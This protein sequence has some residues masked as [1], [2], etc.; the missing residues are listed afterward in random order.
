MTSTGVRVQC[1]QCTFAV[2]MKSET[3][4]P[5]GISKVVEG[6][7][8]CPNCDMPMKPVASVDTST[9]HSNPGLGQGLSFA[10]RLEAIRSAEYEVEEAERVLK[11]RKAD[12]TE[13]RELYDAKVVSLRSIINRLTSVPKPGE[14]P[15]LDL[16]AATCGNVLPATAVTPELTCERE[17][18][19]EGQHEATSVLND[20]DG[21]PHSWSNEAERMSRDTTGDPWCGVLHTGG[22]VAC[23]RVHGHAGRHIHHA[24]SQDESDWTIW[25][26][27]PA[28]PQ[29][30]QRDPFAWD[31]HEGLV[32]RLAAVGI[33][34]TVDDAIGW[35][36][37]Q[38]DE[39]VAYLN[40]REIG[41]AIH[42]V[43]RPDFL[44]LMVIEPPPDPV[45]EALPPPRR[46]RPR[47]PSAATAEAAATT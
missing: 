27:E 15:I 19:H 20:V 47:R 6:S 24:D 7:A 14:K 25:Q 44:P 46:R 41:R 29:V 17:P 38:Y 4:C 26:P 40:A 2:V 9:K 10:E 23:T 22:D 11:A 31:A 12:A 33:G 42:E 35:T 36:T 1:P 34:V 8:F 28:E 5:P 45:D 37:A 30:D 43:P 39:A 18:G 13:A 21:T 3:E 32:T 16:A